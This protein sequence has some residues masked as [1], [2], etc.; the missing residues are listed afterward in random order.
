M[1]VTKETVRLDSKCQIELIN[2]NIVS[3]HLSQP[4]VDV[5]FDRLVG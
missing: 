3:I 1:F 4:E 2:A 5:K